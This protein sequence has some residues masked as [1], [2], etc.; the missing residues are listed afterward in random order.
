MG[1]DFNGDPNLA[2]IVELGLHHEQQHQELVLTD[3]KHAL[4]R[5]P[6]RPAY[7]ELRRPSPAAAGKT[8][9]NH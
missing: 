5:N 7:R 9:L 8:C 2:A 4:S 6:T 1:A 3:V